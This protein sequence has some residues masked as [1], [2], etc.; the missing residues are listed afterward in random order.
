[1]PDTAQLSDAAV[2]LRNRSWWDL[3][4]RIACLVGAGG[5]IYRAALIALG[6]PPTNSDEATM[7]LAA[8]HISRGEDFPVFFY[9]QSYM[10]TIEAYLAAPMF[11]V[12]GPSTVALRLPTLLC[13]LVFVVGMFA[14][15]RL[16]VGPWPAVVTT[17]VLAL[18]SDRVIKNQLIAAGGYP[19]ISP[20]AVWLILLAALLG[21]GVLRPRRWILALCGAVAGLLFWTHWLILPY[22]A[23][24][25]AVLFLALRRSR[26]QGRG[27][28]AWVLLG[29]IVGAAPLLWHDLTSPLA[30]NSLA[31]FL[32]QSDPG[33]AA[34]V[35]GRMSG[36]VLFG[37][38]MGVG[39]CSPGRCEPWQVAWAIPYLALLAAAGVLAARGIRRSDSDQFRNVVRLALVLAAVVSIVAYA[40]SSA[41]AATPVESARYLSPLLISTPVVLWPLWR[42]TARLAAADSR[43]RCRHQWAAVVPSA[44]LL[45]TMAVATS[46]LMLH[47]PMVQAV[48]ARRDLLAA[49]L[50]Q[51][52]VSEVYADYWTC[53]RLTFATRERVRCAV[54]NDDLTPGLDRY[55]P[56]RQAVAS[57]DRPAY[58]APTQHALDDRLRAWLAGAGLSH[59][60]TA[61]GDHRVYLPDQPHTRPTSP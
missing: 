16:V 53:N 6:A 30:E 52:G 45:S 24:A 51:T 56:Y 42:L 32:G 8:L 43:L 58:V 39:L 47:V 5:L 40:R 19:E 2:E 44:A 31:V 27:G 13:Y 14:L 21:V 26:G 23:A 36:G 28:P 22:L 50:V 12:F 25:A 11:W 3:P 34:S 48:E 57:A 54:L 46:G 38:P 7:G 59:Q 49:H 17:A 33:D 1:M 15:S 60:V 10:G 29:F 20:G 41:A 55:L 35:A 4:T 61:V 9:G 37:I 18:G